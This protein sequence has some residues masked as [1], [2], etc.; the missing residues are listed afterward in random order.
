MRFLFILYRKIFF[1]IP[2]YVHGILRFELI[3]FFG[4]LSST[5]LYLDKQK[6]NFINLGCGTLITPN[7]INIDFFG[8]PNI[9]FGADLRRPLKINSAAADGIFCEHTLEHLSYHDVENLLEDCFRVLKQGGA[10][11][12]I[13]PDVSIFIKNY[14]E[15]KNGWFDKWEALMFTNSED[16]KRRARHIDT[17]LQAIS[18]VM[19]EHG[20]VSAWDFET[21][22]KI[23]KR[24]GFSDVKKTSYRQGNS[25]SLL[26]DSDSDDRRYV[27]LYIEATK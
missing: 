18:F 12:I 4:N 16:S 20:H 7:F 10:I 5:S 3:A 26:I 6:K 9:D 11:R 17:P 21:F 8:V 13:V 24:V 19:Q 1:F 2:S 27:S 14:Y 23:L 15:K 25:K 22:E